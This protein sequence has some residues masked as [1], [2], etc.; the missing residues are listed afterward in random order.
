M[1]LNLS[2][3]NLQH[4]ISRYAMAG[5]SVGGSLAP[6][7][8]EAEAALAALREETGRLLL[9]QEDAILVTDTQWAAYQNLWPEADKNA[10][11]LVS[12]MIPALSTLS[13]TGLPSVTTG[14]IG[15]GGIAKAL[16]TTGSAATTFLDT[17]ATAISPDNITGIFTAAFTGAGG[18]LGALKA[19]GSQLVGALSKHFLTPLSTSI[20]NGVKGIFTGGA[21]AGAAG[22]AAGTAGGAAGSGL[23]FAGVIAAIPGWGWAAAGFA[24]AAIFISSFRNHPGLP[25]LGSAEMKQGIANEAA[26]L[27]QT[28]GVIDTGQGTEQ[29]PSQARHRGGPVSAGQSYSTIPGEVFTPSTNG[30]IDNPGLIDYDKLGEAVARAM[31]RAPLHVSRDAVTDAMLMPPGVRRSTDRVAL[32]SWAAKQL[33]P[34]LCALR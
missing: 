27:R 9:K 22:G 19:I 20:F 33:G 11:I 10:D 23:G 6:S 32:S 30:R 31:Q 13:M 1:A 12:R 3:P 25:G 24:A 26:W 16:A 18:A 17:M 5:D 4:A 8:E 15:P 29:L 7:A 2:S 34:A 14:L 28:G 21:A